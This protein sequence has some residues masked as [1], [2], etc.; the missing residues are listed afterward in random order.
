M[1]KQLNYLVRSA[2]RPDLAAVA[3][4]DSAAYGDYTLDLMR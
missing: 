4:L 3:E 1:S 2:T